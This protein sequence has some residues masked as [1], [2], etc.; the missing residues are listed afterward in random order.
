[1]E[2]KRKIECVMSIIML[3]VFCFIVLLTDGS[4]RKIF[5][6]NISRDDSGSSI[7]VVIYPGHGG[8]DPG[9]V[10]IN[11]EL[12]KEINLKIA[13][14]VKE[15]LTKQGINVVMT[16]ESDMS[17]D[18]GDENVKSKKASDMARRLKIIEEANPDIMV[19]IHQ[20]SYSSEKVKGAQV[21]YYAGSDEGK[22]LAEKLQ[23]V[24]KRDVDADNTRKAKD[25]TSYYMLLRIQCPAVIVE[26][27]FLS[28]WEEA[29]ALCDEIYQNKMATAICDGIVEYFSVTEDNKCEVETENISTGNVN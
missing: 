13:L 12:E 4:I 29:T 6:S 22:K 25:N 20:N 15:L 19:S 14:K 16:R 3:I 9:K 7:T 8:Y 10:G 5:A 24:I 2:K 11:G 21:F 26:C 18:N 1:M 28:N 27:G 23:D 17:M